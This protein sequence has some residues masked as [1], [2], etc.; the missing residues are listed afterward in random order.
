VNDDEVKEWINVLM[1]NVD[2]TLDGL[3]FPDDADAA[4]IVEAMESHFE[5]GTLLRQIYFWTL[6]R[7]LQTDSK[8]G[9]NTDAQNL[10]KFTE[11]MMVRYKILAIRNNDE[12][13]RPFH[14]TNRRSWHS[15]LFKGLTKDA[16]YEFAADTEPQINGQDIVM[17]R[18]PGSSGIQV[19][20]RIQTS[21]FKKKIA[22][23][24]PLDTETVHNKQ[25]YAIHGELGLML[26]IMFALPPIV[27]ANWN[28]AETGAIPDQ[29]LHAMYSRFTGPLQQI[30]RARRTNQDAL[31]QLEEDM[32]KIQEPTSLSSSSITSVPEDIRTWAFDLF[33]TLQA[34]NVTTK[35]LFIMSNG[36][37]HRCSTLHGLENFKLSRVDPRQ[38]NVVWHRKNMWTEDAQNMV[39]TDLTHHF[40]FNSMFLLHFGEALLHICPPIALLRNPSVLGCLSLEVDRTTTDYD[41]YNFHNGEFDAIL[42]APNRP[43]QMPTLRQLMFEVQTLQSDFGAAWTA[44]RPPFLHPSSWL[45]GYNPLRLPDW[46]P[47]PDKHQDLIGGKVVTFH[48]AVGAIQAHAAAAAAAA[49]AALPAPAPAAPAA[50]AAPAWQAVHGGIS[51]QN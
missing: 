43:F 5:F 15:L 39:T 28:L 1:S 42:D 4:T 36:I 3:G 51:A 34:H 31:D 10:F 44:R 41:L 33:N 18:V 40:A 6:E 13:V 26:D 30:W 27:L 8:D 24:S 16:K 45:C 14:D 50:A 48:P 46:T 9:S 12:T 2:V 11:E 38:Q 23:E 49:A 19:V 25:F 22:W 47:C 21:V 17:Q 20:P 29:S 7:C 35:T 37:V 32:K